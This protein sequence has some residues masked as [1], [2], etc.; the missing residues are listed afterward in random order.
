M[1]TL[2]LEE[3]IL[4]CKKLPKVELHAHLNGC[5]RP[6]T[7]CELANSSSDSV[8]GDDAIIMD[9]IRSLGTVDNEKSLKQLLQRG[10]KLFDMIH[11]VTH[12]LESI[13]RITIETIEDC[14]ADNV[15]YLEIRTTPRHIPDT[16]MTKRSYVETVLS[17][18]KNTSPKHDIIVGLLL[19]INR[20]ESSEE[21]MET[22]KLAIEYSDKGVCG[23]DL[24][25][26]PTVGK[27][28]TFIPALSHAKK[29]GMKTTIHF[30]E[31]YNPDESKEMLDFKPDRLGH[32]C[33]LN[34]ELRTHVLNSNIPIEICL[35]SNVLTKSV[36]GYHSHHFKEYF[37]AKHPLSLC[38][39][40]YGIMS[41]SLSREFG[42]AAQHFKLSFSDMKDIT[43]S[44]IDHTFADEST[45]KKLREKFIVLC[46]DITR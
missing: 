29:S 28:S 19:S 38:T 18:I 13:E 43:L 22:V 14:A 30:A 20:K 23:I 31:V 1:A 37:A 25:G 15:K 3:W 42:L 17:A 21:A 12:T 27:F 46:Q 6:S 35:S 41:T 45:K 26:N 2:G 32:V 40:D 9:L 5:I 39:D 36:S 34:D 33:Y 16:P 24:S 4:W 8:D 11:K 10:F 44:S 7:L